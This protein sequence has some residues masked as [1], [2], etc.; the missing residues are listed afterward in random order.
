MDEQINLIER[1]KQRMEMNGCGLFNFLLKKRVNEHFYQDKLK[2]TA[3]TRFDFAPQDLKWATDHIINP[4]VGTDGY[5]YYEVMVDVQ[6]CGKIRQFNRTTQKE[7][8]NE[9]ICFDFTIRVYFDDNGYLSDGNVH[10]L[11]AEQKALI[12]YQ[13]QYQNELQRTGSKSIIESTYQGREAFS[14]FTRIWKNAAIQDTDMAGVTDLH[15]FHELAE[16]HRNV[17]Y[18]VSCASMWGRYISHHSDHAYRMEEKTVYQLSTTFYDNR[19]I[20]YLEAA[21]EELYTF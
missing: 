9:S 13:L 4:F 10:L 3:I 12:N 19:H 20:F 5:P 7:F 16:A 11:N 8:V 2:K 6:A 1:L 18:S 17:M 14:F 21:M 15:Y